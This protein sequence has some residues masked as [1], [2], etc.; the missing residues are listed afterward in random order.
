MILQQPRNTLV[1]TKKFKCFSTAVDN[2]P[3]VDLHI[4]QRERELVCNNKSL[5]TIRLGNI[6]LAP[7]GIP[8]IEVIFQIDSNGILSVTAKDKGTNQEQSVTIEDASTLSSDEI[9]KM[10]KDAELNVK[11]DLKFVD[12]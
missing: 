10:V 3:A 5:S 7:R 12:C 11:K 4:L 9:D 8:V 1:P 2:Q 6:P